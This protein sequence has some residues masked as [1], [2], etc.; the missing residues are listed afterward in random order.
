MIVRP[1]ICFDYTLRC[2]FCLDC[3]FY[4]VNKSGEYRIRNSVNF[5]GVLDYRLSSVDHSRFVL[6]CL[7]SQPV[8]SKKPNAQKSLMWMGDMIGAIIH[9]AVFKLG[10]FGSPVRWM[11]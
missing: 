8:L 2:P 5:S 3:R 6:N 4:E 10:Y 9:S 11:Q 1:Y 7:S